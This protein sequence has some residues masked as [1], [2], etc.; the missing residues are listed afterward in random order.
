MSAAA[1]NKA[2]YFDCRDSFAATIET[3]T[4]KLRILYKEIFEVPRKNNVYIILL[5]HYLLFRSNR[6]PSSWRIRSILVG[7]YITNDRDI[8]RS[9]FPCLECY[10]TL[11]ACT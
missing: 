1:Q 8:I 10:I 9:N 4:F 11:S 5:F 6:Y 3:L 2:G 7:I